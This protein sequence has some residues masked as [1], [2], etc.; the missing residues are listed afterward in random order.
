MKNDSVQGKSSEAYERAFEY[1]R[2]YGN[3]AQA[4]LKALLDVFRE[5]N[6]TA[7]RGMGRES[8]TRE[9]AA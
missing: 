2:D 6:D 9:E 1:E 5:N 7:Y 3:C 4:T 8:N